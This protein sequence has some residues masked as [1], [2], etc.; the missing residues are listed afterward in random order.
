MD[1]TFCEQKNALIPPERIMKS[2]KTA[3]LSF[4]TKLFWPKQIQFEATQGILNNVQLLEN[5]ESFCGFG[6]PYIDNFVQGKKII[7][8]F[9]C[10]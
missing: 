3:G 5:H 6:P 9:H 7:V 2:K 10:A 8:L 4:C 1:N